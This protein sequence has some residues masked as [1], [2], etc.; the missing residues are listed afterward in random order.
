[1]LKYWLSVFFVLSLWNRG[2][3]Q[4]KVASDA[5]TAEDAGISQE[6]SELIYQKARVLPEGVQISLAIIQNGDVSF[7]GVVR[8]ND[9]II[10]TD[11]SN[12]VFE[13]G[14][15]TKVFTATILANLALQN[16]IRLEDNI[17]DHL[18]YTI[19]NAIPITFK[20]LATHS[21]G[22]PR[23]PTSL[24]SPTLS[25]ENPYKD[26][27]PEEL[28]QYFLEDF[29]LAFPPGEKSEYSNLGVGLLGYVLSKVA[30]AP[31]EDLLQ[32]MVFERYQMSSSTTLR[33]RIEPLLIPG[34]SESGHK[35]PN[36]DMGVLMGAGGIL[37]TTEDLSKFALAHFED[38]NKELALSRTPFYRVTNNYSMGLAWGIITNDS[39]ADW[40]WHNGGTGGYTS[41][42]ILNSDTKNGV[43]ILSNLSALGKLSANIT[44]LSPALMSTL[45]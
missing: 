22:L 26:F 40:L 34:L 16:R 21:S 45:E 23:V 39:G 27:G 19:R 20:Q 1:M 13:I 30:D 43:I 10:T 37:S 6:Q 32:K 5:Q 4:I 29:E 12:K 25:L 33:S 38:S 28:K 3:A 17:N 18:D 41:S 8:N 15:I 35:V 44:S 42:M 2:L 9:S 24:S 31:Y 36:W 11:N 7:Y 14:S